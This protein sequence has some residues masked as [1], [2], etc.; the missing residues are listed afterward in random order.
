MI[1]DVAISA[2]DYWQS[3]LDWAIYKIYE[4]E[5][6]ENDTTE[7]PEMMPEMIIAATAR[8]VFDGGCHCGAVRFRVT[9]PLGKNL[10]LPLS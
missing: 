2:L 9:G 7:N 8:K 5:F 4:V 10:N 6:R 1:C 3:R